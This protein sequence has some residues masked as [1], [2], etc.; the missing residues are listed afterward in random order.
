MP[1]TYPGP[2]NPNWKGGRTI[3]SSGYVLVK[4]RDHPLA[5]VRGYVYEHRL[6]A[7]EVLGRLLEKDEEVHHR[8]G[9][10]TDNRP[11]N[12]EI[13]P[14]RAIHALQHRTRH[15]LRRPDEGNPIIK[16]ACGC[17]EN[18]A[19]FDGFGRPRKFMQGHNNR[20]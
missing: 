10:K 2:R 9:D 15:D 5:D 8:N 16:C 19:K 13:M 4:R 12:L 7:C 1:K 20:R 3:A 6:V 11:E 14:S 17:G 18:L